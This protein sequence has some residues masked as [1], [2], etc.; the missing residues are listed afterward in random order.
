M[1]RSS[2]CDYSDVYILVNKTAIVL[3]TA[4]AGRAANNKKIY[5]IIKT[6]WSIY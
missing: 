4:A 6:L 3:N 1:L 2:L 5:I